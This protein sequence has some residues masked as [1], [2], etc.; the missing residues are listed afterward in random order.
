MAT[1]QSTFMFMDGNIPI[2]VEG[3]LVDWKAFPDFGPHVT[4]EPSGRGPLV[5]IKHDSS[6][7]EVHEVYKWGLEMKGIG[8]SPQIVHFINLLKNTY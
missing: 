3:Q 8:T 7:E 4:I 1:P 2:N 5:R 6:V